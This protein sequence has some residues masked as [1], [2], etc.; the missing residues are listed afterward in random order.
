MVLEEISVKSK[1]EKDERSRSIVNIVKI[2][3]REILVILVKP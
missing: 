3:K 2:L 1:E